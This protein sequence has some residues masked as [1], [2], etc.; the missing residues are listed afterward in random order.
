MAAVRVGRKVRGSRTVVAG[1]AA[2]ALAL[3]A[4]SIAVASGVPPTKA[5]GKHG[6]LDYHQI[7]GH[8]TQHSPPGRMHVVRVVHPNG[9]KVLSAKSP[10]LIRGELSTGPGRYRF[11]SFA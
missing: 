11:V 9:N 7:N 1:V 10:G 2:G 8:K 5:G 3:G 4:V 6:V